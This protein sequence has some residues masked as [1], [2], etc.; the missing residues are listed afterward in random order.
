MPNRSRREAVRQWCECGRPA[1]VLGRV[2]RKSSKAVR[3][4][5]PVQMPGHYLCIKCHKQQSDRE[6]RK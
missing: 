6:R 5:R 2:R 4:G 3:A 1:V